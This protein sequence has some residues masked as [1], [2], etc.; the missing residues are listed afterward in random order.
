MNVIFVGDVVGSGGRAAVKALLGDVKREFNAH[1]AIV[2]GENSAAGAGLTAKC[3][4]ELASAGANVITGGDH[5]WDQKS[6]EGEAGHLKN[7]IRPANFSAMQ[8]GAGFGIWNNPAGGDVAVIS[9]LGKVFMRESAC[10]PFETAEKI[11]REIPQRVT[12]IFVDFHAEATSEKI[13]M[14]RFLDGRVTAV[15]GTHTHVQTADAAVLPG[16]TALLSD[17]GMT[18]A[19]ESVLGRSVDDVCRKFRTGM[20]C[21]LTV[22]DKGRFRMDFAVVS[23]DHLSGKATAIKNYSRYVEL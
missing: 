15:V 7:F 4:E 8:P 14:A 21:R 23:Y 17:V 9:L 19:D 11:L 12:S 5:T 2:N 6:F 20:P 3:V 10:C 1:F 22:V 13:A 16:G 18:G